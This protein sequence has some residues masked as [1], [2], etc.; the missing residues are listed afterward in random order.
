MS[1]LRSAASTATTRTGSPPSPRPGSCPGQV[2]GQ[3]HDECPPQQA[4]YDKRGE[5]RPPRD[6]FA[7]LTEQHP[8]G[9]KMRRLRLGDPLSIV[10][11]VVIVVALVAAS[12]LGAELYA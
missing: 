10:L 11:I 8:V 6:M 3:S 4:R 5:G 1:S 7:P 12:L 9:P 2:V